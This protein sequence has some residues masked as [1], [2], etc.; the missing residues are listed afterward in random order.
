MLMKDWKKGFELAVIVLLM[1]LMVVPGRSEAED[2]VQG[3]VITC[4]QLGAMSWTDAISVTATLVPAVIT[5][6]PRAAIPEHCRVTGR[7][8]PENDFVIKLPSAWNARF[9]QVGNG[10]AAGN[11][12]ESSLETGLL[13]GYAAATG[14]GG[15]VGDGSSFYMMYPPTTPD[16]VVK[17]DDY[18][19]GSVHRINVL[20]KQMMKAYYGTEPK[21]SY[22]NTCS[23]GGR[24]GL[25]EAQRFPEDFDGI[26]VSNPVQYI[27]KI[28]MRDT[29]QAQQVFQS[30][31][32]SETKMPLLGTLVMKKCDGLDGLVD[33]M[34]DDPRNCTFNGA[35]DITGAYKCAD[36]QDLPTCFTAKEITAIKN[37]QDG[38]KTTDGTVRFKGAPYGAE[39]LGFNIMTGSASSG[40]SGSILPVFGMPISLGGYMG[41]GMQQWINLP[42]ATGGGGPTW[43]YNAFT[44]DVG[45]DYDSVMN[46]MEA[47]CDAYDPNL[48]PFKIRGGKL[49]MFTGWS[50]P[51]VSPY[52]HADYVDQVRSWMGVADTEDFFKAYFIPGLYHCAGGYG[53]S[54]SID[55]FGAMTKWVEKGVAPGA[56]VGS[57]SKAPGLYDARTRPICPYPRVARYLG[58]GSIDTATSFT[59]V[60]TV[61]TSVAIKPAKASLSAGTVFTASITIPDG[62]E[63]TKFTVVTCEGALAQKGGRF[64]KNGNYVVRF[65]ASDLKG[66]T[67]GTN[68][69]FTVT[70]MF[71]DD[72]GTIY[73]LEGT[74]IMS[75]VTGKPKPKKPGS[76]KNP[77]VIE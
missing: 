17:I 5:S 24:Q 4:T 25:I 58:S 35:L 27:T 61:P 7:Q 26:V 62:Y 40:W 29:W 1:V 77:Y 14:N 12:S 20:A 19:T 31:G 37:I 57:R 2:T 38:I 76:I 51:L 65:K 23:T 64:D 8:L 55:W 42:L 50:D 36:G 16:N 18:C 47:R 41:T 71:T 72:D 59:C 13:K 67:A 32:I 33:S 48:W 22:Y 21:Y 44:F 52:M 73:A 49:L 3:S 9:Y 75:T 54:E 39:P 69:P 68:V 34:I 30:G 66:I 63:P 6:T 46:A 60:T 45:G 11:I 10:G 56:F 28:T 53:C 43:N 70:A 74:Q 15:H